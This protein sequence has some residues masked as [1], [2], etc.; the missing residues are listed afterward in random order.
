M[1]MNEKILEDI[2]NF[3]SNLTAVNK[4]HHPNDERRLYN[5]ALE[6]VRSGVGV[7]CKEMRSAFERVVK[8]QNLSENLFND[9]YPEYIQVIERAYDMLSRLNM[10]KTLDEDFRF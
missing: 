8:E 2:N 9:F 10:K 7:P 5:I 3:M 6:A 1:P 4:L